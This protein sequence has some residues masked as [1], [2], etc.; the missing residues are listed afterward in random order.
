M[1]KADAWRKLASGGRD[2]RGRK[3][4]DGRRAAERQL[5][6]VFARA[7]VQT[8]RVCSDELGIDLHGFE[9][10][11]PHVHDRRLAVAGVRHT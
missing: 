7:V 8:A 5:D 6:I 2:P 11:R 1:R 10:I 4:L 9:L 3:R